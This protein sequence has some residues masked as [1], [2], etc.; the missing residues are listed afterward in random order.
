MMLRIKMLLQIDEDASGVF[1]THSLERAL[2]E[3]VPLLNTREARRRT[4]NFY[5]V[6][7]FFHF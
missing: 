2:C 4:E 5:A 6:S 3:V 7:L 1:C